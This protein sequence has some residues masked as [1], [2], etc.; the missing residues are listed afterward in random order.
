MATHSPQLN[1]VGIC[2]ST[3]KHSY[4][5]MLLDEAAKMLPANVTYTQVA[6]T[7]LPFFNQ[8]DEAN[9]PDAVKAF[10][11]P[12]KQADAILISTPEYNYSFPGILKN[13][14]EWVSRASSGLPVAEK[15]FALIGASGGMFGPAR[16]MMHLRQVLFAMNAYPVNRPEVYVNAAAA[17]FN[18]DGQLVD[19]VARDFTSQ[20]LQNLLTAA[21]QRKELQAQ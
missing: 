19:E 7:G 6:I 14:L 15:P 12:L 13:A 9:L 4:N 2:G 5:Q 10:I 17:K 8:D 21:T 1:I 18:Q 3:R 20:L 11:E 16:G